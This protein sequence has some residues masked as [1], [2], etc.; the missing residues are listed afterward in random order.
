VGDPVPEAERAGLNDLGPTALGAHTDP[1]VLTLLLQDDCGGLQAQARDGGWLDVEPRPGTVVV[2]LGDTTQ[3]R[4]NDRYRAAVHRVLPM[5]ASDRY[6]IPLFFNPRR[7]A[8]VEPI[9]ALADGVPA[10][11]PFTWR[12]FIAGRTDDNYADLGVD[13]IQI[14]RF[15][16]A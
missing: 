3:V 10:Y 6:S 14:D 5:T 2:N 8:V 9:G 7:D 16:V 1:G 11:H 15:R 12:E 13:D 4:T